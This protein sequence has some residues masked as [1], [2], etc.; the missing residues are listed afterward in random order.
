M[1]FMWKKYLKQMEG[2]QQTFI[3]VKAFYKVNVLHLFLH[4]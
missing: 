4:E 3:P 2:K 1:I